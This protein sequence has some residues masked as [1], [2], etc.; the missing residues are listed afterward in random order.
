MA[1]TWTQTSP[2]VYQANLDG[3]ETVYRKTATVFA[4]LKRE[5]WRLH[6]ICRFNFGPGYNGPTDKETALRQAWKALRYEF[7]GMTVAPD[8]SKKIYKTP[9][10][11]TTKEWLEQTFFVEPKRT[12][13]EIIAEAVPLQE[14]PSLYYL[15]AT[16]EILFFISHWRI[17]AMG[18]W[19]VTDRLFHHLANPSKSGLPKVPPPNE[20]EK[21]S[22]SLEDAAGSPKVSTPEM[23]K[24]AADHIAAH[25]RNAIQMGGMPYKGDAITLP[26]SPKREAVI[27]TREST[28]KVVSACKARGITVTAAIHAALAET[29]FAMGLP[30]S[31]EHDYVTVMPV[32]LRN[33][34]KT[35]YNGDGHALQTYAGSITPRVPRHATF[36]KRTSYLVE[37]YK[38]RYDPKLIECLRPI[39]RYHAEALFKPLPAPAAAPEGT[40][41]TSNGNKRPPPGLP[42]GISINS[43]G[44]VEKY[45]AGKYGDSVDVATFTF[46]VSMI[47][48]QTML[49]VWTWKGELTLSSEYNA[50]Y[51][52]PEEVREV[53][54]SIKQVLEKELE[55]EQNRKREVEEQKE[56]P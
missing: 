5:H 11:R 8:R 37:Y 54:L 50:A 41:A 17:D 15:P 27:F 56:Q 39:Y 55:I 22:P 48:R 45:F 16:S 24:V 14:V 1:T 3:A 6:T 29:V 2:G 47:T 35:P 13:D 4:P 7:P 9:D 46:G 53:M 40:P 28:Q 18:S 31:R 25:H 34:L 36:A 43:L 33:Y 51:H 32:N 12:A 30:E 21:I 20:I 44:V 10:A 23:D 19:M 52:D 26:G 38:T 42:S 49:Y